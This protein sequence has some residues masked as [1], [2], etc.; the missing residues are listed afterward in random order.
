MGV[1][2]RVSAFAWRYNLFLC[3]AAEMSSGNEKRF[4]GAFW[5]IIRV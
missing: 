4:F 1:G 5:I 2:N 3:R